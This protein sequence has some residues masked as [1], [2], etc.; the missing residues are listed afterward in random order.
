MG[1]T[2]VDRDPPLWP[3]ESRRQHRGADALARLADRGVGQAD[4]LIG[5]QTGRD[6]DLDGDASSVDPDERGT[7]D[8]G[9]HGDLSKFEGCD[10]HRRAPRLRARSSR[11]RIG[12]SLT[13]GPDA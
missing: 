5:G 4:D 11:G 12:A 2:E 3:F 9:E 13:E 10:T 1:F 6:V 7:A 8:H